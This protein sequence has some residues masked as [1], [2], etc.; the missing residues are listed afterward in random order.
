MI[1]HSP[2]S[3]ASAANPT[4]TQ[5]T[6]SQPVPSPTSSPTLSPSLSDHQELHEEEPVPAKHVRKLSQCIQDLIEGHGTTS[7]CPSNPTVST[8]IQLPPIVEEDPNLVLEGEGLAD[9]MMVADFEEEHMMA[10]EISDVEA[11]ELRFLVKAKHHPD[12]PLWKKGIHEELALLQETSTW[13]LTDGPAQANIVGSKW[14]FH[15]KKDA[16]GNIICYKAHLIVQGFSQVP[17]VDYLC[18]NFTS[19]GIWM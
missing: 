8:G 13:E 5:P 1:T 7:A 6:L 18:W 9:W 17:S 11:L 3:S 4:P 14:V 2:E 19:A 15:R 12:W 16:A 10:A